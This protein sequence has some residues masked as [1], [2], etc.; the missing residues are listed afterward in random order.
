MA[1]ATTKQKKLIN[2]EVVKKLFS[3]GSEAS[4]EYLLKIVSLATEIPYEKLKKGFHLIHP[5]AGM[6]ANTVDS[7]LDIA[8]ETEDYFISFEINLSKSK[9]VDVK[10]GSYTIVLYLRQLTSSKEYKNL[11]P[12]Y[13]VNLDDFD[14]FGDNHFIYRS[15]LK[16]I[17]TNKSR[18]LDLYVIDINLDYLKKLGYN[19]IRN[20]NE[21]EKLL[22]LFCSDEEQLDELYEGDKMMGSIR[23]EAN[24]LVNDLDLMLYY[25]KEDLQRQIEEERFEDDKQEGEQ[26]GKLQKQKEVA[27]K[28]LE[29]SDISYIAEVTGLTIEEIEALKDETQE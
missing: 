16:E 13:Q 26:A 10:N 14:Y 25:N 18:H 5:N 23:K 12:V 19:N 1:T 15:E 21:L 9:S 3:S 17:E 20:A 4:Q 2:D 7:E 29:K 11:K 8:F 6:N 27:K 28:M 22:Y 24:Q